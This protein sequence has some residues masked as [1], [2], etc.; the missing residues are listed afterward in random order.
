[1]RGLDAQQIIGVWE[2]GRRA[3][4]HTRAVLLAEQ[5]GVEPERAAQLAIGA[6]DRVLAEQRVA[7][8]GAVAPAYVVCPACSEGLEFRVDFERV[9]ELGGTS[10]EGESFTLEHEAFRVEFRLPSTADM[11]AITADAEHGRA[12]LIE[13]II[14]VA[15][16]QG[17]RVSPA[18]L[19]DS[20]IAELEAEIE[21]LDPVSDIRFG[22]NCPACQ[23]R[24]VA[25]FD[26]ARFCW[27]ELDVDA[28]RLL[29]EVDVL[30]RIYGWSEA[31][32]LGLSRTRRSTYLEICGVP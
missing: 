16:R 20:V 31:E 12:V 8:Y 21:R 9:C 15:E 30:A 24:F 7:T 3:S 32:I 27:H 23:H 17:D 26:V 2:R 14:L 5:A 25:P 6:R 1:V 28:R 22:Q 11:L 18:A 13:R 29:Q 19:P 4:S 10:P